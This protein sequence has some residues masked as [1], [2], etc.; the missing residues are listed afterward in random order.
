VLHAFVVADFTVSNGKQ[1]GGETMGVLTHVLRY[2]ER[3]RG[4]AIG[5]VVTEH[6]HEVAVGNADDE[7]ARDVARERFAR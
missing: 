4:D 7:I 3:Y 6:N 1:T 5:V 2:L